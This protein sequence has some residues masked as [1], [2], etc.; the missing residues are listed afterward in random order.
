MRLKIAAFAP[1][2]PEIVSPEQNTVRRVCVQRSPHL[3]LLES[4]W[5]FHTNTTPDI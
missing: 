4:P 2:P 5:I 3:R 1:I